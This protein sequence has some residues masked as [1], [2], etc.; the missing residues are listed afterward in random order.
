MY[1]M[2][3]LKLRG[4]FLGCKNYLN[5]EEFSLEKS[6]LQGMESKKSMFM[7]PFGAWAMPEINPLSQDLPDMLEQREGMG[8]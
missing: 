4:W 8:I 5:P 1:G 3:S 7:F 2:N 6:S